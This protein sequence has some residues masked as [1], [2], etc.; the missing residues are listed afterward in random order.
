M[1]T[2]PFPVGM[3]AG[4][5][6]FTSKVSRAHSASQDDWYLS[7]KKI[8]LHITVLCLNTYSATV[9]LDAWNH[10]GHVTHICVSKINIIG[11]YNGLRLLGGSQPIIWTSAEILSIRTLWIYFSEILNEICTFSFRKM[12]SKMPPAK[13][14]HFFFSLNVI[15]QSNSLW[16]DCT[17]DLE[18]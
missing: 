14:R 5:I 15:T 18:Y 8:Q 16:A 17:L 6:Q 10:W 2:C 7:G 12:H 3:L 9:H 11:S 1:W 4:N 13:L